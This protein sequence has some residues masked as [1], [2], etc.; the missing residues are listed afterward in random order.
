MVK[1]VKR[2]NLELSDEQRKIMRRALEVYVSDLRAEIVKTEK[3]EWKQGLHKE[4]D[5][6]KEIIAKVA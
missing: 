3:H 5:V 2:M 6:L 1:E 4:K